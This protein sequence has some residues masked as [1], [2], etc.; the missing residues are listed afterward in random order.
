MCS[1]RVDDVERDIL[2][3]Y[4][5]EQAEFPGNGTITLQEHEGKTA[6]IWTHHTQTGFSPSARLMT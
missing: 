6:A 3:Q 5:V 1:M 4:T 2:V